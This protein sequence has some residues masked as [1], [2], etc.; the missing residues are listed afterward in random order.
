M[1]TIL[2]SSV[3][4]PATLYYQNPS[5]DGNPTSNFAAPI[6][7]D[8]VVAHAQAYLNA[9]EGVC[10]QLC[11]SPLTSNDTARLG[12][13]FLNNVT[14]AHEIEDA[15]VHNL[16]S[17]IQRHYSQLRGVISH[18]CY[19]HS[20][21]TPNEVLAHIE[22]PFATPCS[23]KKTLYSHV[24]SGATNLTHAALSRLAQTASYYLTAKKPEAASAEIVIPPAPPLPQPFAAAHAYQQGVVEKL[25]ILS[26]NLQE[27]SDQL[28]ADLNTLKVAQEIGDDKV[29]LDGSLKARIT[30]TKVAYQRTLQEAEALYSDMHALFTS[31]QKEQED[32]W[33]HI[34][35]NMKEQKNSAVLP[36]R[37]ESAE[38]PINTP[39]PSVTLLAG[40]TQDPRL[41]LLFLDELRETG[42][43]VYPVPGDGHCSLY[44]LFKEP[45]VLR[46][47]RLFF[48]PGPNKAGPASFL[49]EDPAD[50]L[51]REIK[52]TRA[53]IRERAE[54]MLHQAGPDAVNIRAIMQFEMTECE[55]AQRTYSTRYGERYPLDNASEEQQKRLEECY[56]DAFVN[57]I[58]T[59]TDFHLSVLSTYLGRPIHVYSTDY[60]TNATK[61]QLLHPTNEPTPNVKP[62]QE[63]YQEI[64]VPEGYVNDMDLTNPLRLY[65][66]H[67]HYQAMKPWKA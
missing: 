47:L 25:K 60:L 35:E 40:N 54:P 51:R 22:P 42:L 9:T 17:K 3:F 15:L 61:Q 63:C 4:N 49:P 41:E 31:L 24:I 43:H 1:H 58:V 67:A 55:A 30:Q 21:Q 32:Q 52:L 34:I 6:E 23:T 53:L 44:S 8:P 27:Q 19:P 13:Q 12:R 14:I 11:S 2:S 56:W 18:P 20:I 66:S 16:F 39:R 45:D 36:D 57:G 50:T 7:G 65:H 26:Q 46:V 59:L 64:P 38:H 5:Q 10:Q 37:K 28:Y 62:I 48:Y 29:D 33:K